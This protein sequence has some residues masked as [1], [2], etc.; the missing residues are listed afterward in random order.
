MHSEQ[1]FVSH[2]IFG[3]DPLWVS[4]ILFIVTY[5]VIVTEKVNRAIVSGLGAGLM[6]MYTPRPGSSESGTG[7]SGCRLQYPRAVNGND[8]DRGHHPTLRDLPI[9]SHLVGQASG[10]Q[11]LGYTADAVGGHR[12]VLGITG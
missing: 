4:T 6:I 11:A 9:C 7:R 2:V 8:G 3:W 12:G 5:I 10:S 1:E